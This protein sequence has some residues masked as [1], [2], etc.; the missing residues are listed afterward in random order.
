MF[1]IHDKLIYF[2]CE[3]I[4]KKGEGL[5]VNVLRVRVRTRI[6]V[7]SHFIS[8]LKHRDVS[9]HRGIDK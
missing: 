6:S 2:T 3:R 1:Q 4:V 7:I 8:N 9:S 5:H